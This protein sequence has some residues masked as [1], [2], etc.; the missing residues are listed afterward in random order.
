MKQKYFIFMAMLVLAIFAVG[1]VSA[2][3]DIATDIDVPTDDIAIDDVTVGEVV[4]NN[5]ITDNGGNRDITYDVYEYNSSTEIDNVITAA[6]TGSHVVNFAPGTY[7][8]TVLHM[9]DNVSLIG[10]GA[11]LI[12]TGTS[13]VINLPNYLNNFT[14]SGFIID[15]NNNYQPDKISAIY[16][17]FINNGRIANNIMFNGT[18]GININKNYA[19]MTIED[20]V[21]YNM[22]YDGIS[23]AHPNSNCNIN[24]P[25]Y[26]YISRNNITNCTFGIFS[27]GNFRG[28]ISN[29]NIANCD[30]GIQFAGK[31]DGQISNIIADITGNTIVNVTTGIEFINM[32]AISLY[33]F[34]NV[35]TTNDNSTDYTI[36]YD[37]FNNSTESSIWVLSN[38]LDGKIKQSFI[39]KTFIFLN[40]E[41]GTIEND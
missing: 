40:Y 32:T 26:T 5:E 7:N 13:H 21:I 2:S 34:T 25:T 18:N 41:D 38:T 35:I 12:G 30:C 6:S 3:E 8:D 37:N 36:A 31:K 27:G 1:S 33:I 10:N 11:R 9:K 39:N 29:N 24:D 15:V 28:E 23:L 16:G 20:N 22:S 4:E 19:N 17:S 14:I